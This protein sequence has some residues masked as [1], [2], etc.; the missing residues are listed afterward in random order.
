MSHY[1]SMDDVLGPSQGSSIAGLTDQESLCHQGMGFGARQAQCIKKTSLMDLSINSIICVILGF[2]SVT[3]IFSSFTVTFSCL[4]ACLVI[5]LLAA[6][7][8]EVYL[9]GC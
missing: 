2:V 6:S 4:F 1:E 9:A 3:S 5:F 7:H 8:C